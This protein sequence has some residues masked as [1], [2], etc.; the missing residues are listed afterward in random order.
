MYGYVN[1]PFI[2]YCYF[3]YQKVLYGF[4]ISLLHIKGANPCD[5]HLPE[6]E[7]PKGPL[8]RFNMLRYGGI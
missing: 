3:H 4:V 1:L 5:G 8:R 2:D 7:A 6:T